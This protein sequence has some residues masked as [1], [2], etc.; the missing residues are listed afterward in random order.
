MDIIAEIG[1]NHNGDINIAIELIKVAKL[2]GANVAKFQLYEAK[3]LFPKEN[4]PWYE[5]NCQTEISKDELNII[6][7][8]CN[9]YNIEFMA[10][11]FDEQRVEWLEEIGVKRYKLAS[12]SIH[13]NYLIKKVAET[14]KET[15]VSLGMWNEDDF[16]KLSIENIKFLYCKSIYP[17]PINLYNFNHIDF[18]TYH[19]LSDHS[20]GITA[21]KIAISRGARIIEKHFT[22]NTGMYGPDH[23]CSITPNELNELT[24]FVQEAEYCL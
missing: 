21:P 20:I 19:G 10:S 9:K 7:D 4:N 2:N 6:F 13:D 15:L 24:K 17:T 22:F 23:I 12:R 18:G 14:K 3:K 16:P 5:Y 11:P 1:Q 8:T